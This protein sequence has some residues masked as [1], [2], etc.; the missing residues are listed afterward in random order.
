LGAR[1]LKQ[2]LSQFD[3]RYAAVFAAYNAGGKR[4]KQWLAQSHGLPLDIWIE[5]IPY[6]ETRQYVTAVIQNLL[7]YQ[8]R[9][10]QNTIP[11]QTWLAPMP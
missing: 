7:I 2:L 5:N 3:G 9:L 11:Y 1:Y 10:A 4:S 8:Q 6:K